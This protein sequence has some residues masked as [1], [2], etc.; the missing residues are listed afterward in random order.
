MM[1]IN[2]ILPILAILAA[3]S[4]S[5]E[6]FAEPIPH[7]EAIS[8]SSFRKQVYTKA[9]INLF[10]F[11]PGTKYT[12]LAVAAGSDR[13]ES[14]K[15]FATQPQIGTESASHS[16]AYE[17]TS[18]FRSG[19]NLDFYG[20]TYGTETAPELLT[21]PT[22][23]MTPVIEISEVAD[24]L[25]DLMHSND[26]DARNRNS[27][28]G[29]V[30]LPF[31]HA[32]SAI[33]VLISKQDET[34]DEA[35][36]KQLLDVRV[37]DITL[38]NVAETAQMD[39]VTGEWTWESVGSRTIFHDAEGCSVS[40]TARYIG[41]QD[42]LIVPSTNQQIILSVSLSGLQS[43]NATSQQYEL[44]NKTLAGGE[45]VVDGA[46]TLEIPLRQYDAQGGV[47][48]G[49]L[50]FERNH[51]Y[52]LAVTILRD[53]VR[54][55]AISPQVYE[56][57][58]VSI[59]RQEAVLG[60]PVTF[61]GVVWM[62]RNLGATGYD[63]EN[64]FLNT[65][66]YYYQFSRNIPFIFN[67][68]VW[69]GY[70]N[71]RN[72]FMPDVT[73]GADGQYTYDGSLSTFWTMNTTNLSDIRPV[74]DGNI[75]WGGEDNAAKNVFDRHTVNKRDNASPRNTYQE[76]TFGIH[77]VNATEEDRHRNA[78]FF[79]YDENGNR[80]DTWRTGYRY[81]SFNPSEQTDKTLYP[82]IN[83][84]D[85]GGYSFSTGPRN[86]GNQAWAWSRDDED[87]MPNW[88]AYRN[89]WGDDNS[90][91]DNQ[92]APKGWKIASH[93]EIYTI[94]PEVRV[95]GWVD[96]KAY[97][98]QA[99]TSHEMTGNPTA[100][101]YVGEYDFQYVAGRI[102]L[103]DRGANPGLKDILHSTSYLPVVYGIKHQGTDQAYLIKIEQRESKE[104]LF[105]GSDGRQYYFNYVVISRYPA[106]R[107]D[108]ILTNLNTADPQE[109]SVITQTNLQDFDWSHPAAELYFPMQGY[110]DAGSSPVSE[111]G[112]FRGPFLAEF[113]LSCIMR[114]TSWTGADSPG[115]NHTFYFRN[116]GV[117][118]NTGSR[119]ALGD[120]IRLIRDFSAK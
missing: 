82:A 59:S 100:A 33:N 64:D 74:T 6:H 107:S 95:N 29:T 76:G 58:D 108:R 119:N 50:V 38:K 22:D 91:P 105:R 98:Y 30:L 65:M 66:G 71:N 112:N 62:D 118:S 55:V 114:V 42:L 45:Q 53:N 87:P 86:K 5:K 7:G 109:K 14:G 8:F 26:P 85:P 101:Q 23:G 97:F 41:P 39:V 46:V 81:L 44:M 75:R 83:P 96:D 2:Y 16:I 19:E 17:P 57:V 3:V 47:D 25:P 104:P 60:Q 54:I 73:K 106:T 37:T 117:G 78:L 68:S 4:C 77:T 111:T 63:C 90:N 11:D 20:L 102:R 61:G 92:P 93:K 28:G 49:P 69:S 80:V 72:V 70:K 89:Y 9:D 51:K 103:P 67:Q 56:W 27:A 10:D 24:R 34:E 13:W 31:E 116:S 115:H 40:E 84:G 32:L 113:G 110:I 94:L 12:L 36:A 35:A 120:P 52:T 15:G 21:T 18:V 43:Y 79:T 1:K 48:V 88:T 99:S